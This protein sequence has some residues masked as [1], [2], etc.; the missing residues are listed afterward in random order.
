MIKQ[1]RKTNEELEVAR[2]EL[3]LSA[4]K[5]FLKSRSLA[6]AELSTALDRASSKML[7]IIK[8]AEINRDKKIKRANDA[9]STKEIPAKDEF[10]KTKKAAEDRH[11]HLMDEAAKVLES[12]I[13]P[14]KTSK[15]KREK[16]V[17]PSELVKIVGVVDES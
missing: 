6:D 16:S 5:E 7:R 4:K 14:S 11:A 12:A 8:S 3:E 2:L 17:E 1:N 9:F 10:A 15:P 13:G